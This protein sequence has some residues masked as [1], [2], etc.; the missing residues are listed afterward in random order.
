M[1]INYIIGT[2][3]AILIIVSIGNTILTSSVKKPSPTIE[4]LNGYRQ[5]PDTHYVIDIDGD[6]L[7]QVM[8]VHYSYQVLTKRERQE[9]YR[10]LTK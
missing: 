3:G 10:R 9:L 1:K 8:S 6:T 5:I 7:K 4:L 2:I